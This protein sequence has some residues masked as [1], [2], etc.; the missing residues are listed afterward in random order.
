MIQESYNAA[1]NPQVYEEG[2]LHVLFVGESQTP[3]EHRLGPKVYDYFLLHF[4][5]KGRGQ[6]VNESAVYDLNKGDCFLIHPDQLVSYASDPID[7]WRY[8]W[9]AFTGKTATELVISTGFTP[10]LPVFRAGQCS[11]ISGLLDGVLQTFR[12]NKP[13]SHLLSLGYLYQLM[14]EAKE[15]LIKESPL[16][17]GESGVQRIVKQMIHYMSSQYAHPVSIEQMCASLGYNRAYLSRIFKKETGITPVTY[18]LKLR[19]DKSRHLLRGRPELSIEQIASS[20]GLTDPLYFSR[21][22]HRF[23]GESPSQYRKSVTGQSQVPK[24]RNPNPKL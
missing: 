23:Y 8:R 12:N 4:V 16:P 20:V 10:Q 24:E 13:S 5:E 14:A 9:I 22:F 17:S 11:L 1:A 21:Q 7:P 2:D 18:L 19:I 15:T 6:F 3:A